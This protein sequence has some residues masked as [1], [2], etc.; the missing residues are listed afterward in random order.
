MKIA[1]IAPLLAG[2]LTL[3]AN[4]DPLPSLALVPS[5][6][7]VAG[8][9]GSTVG[10]GYDIDNPDPNNYVVLNDSFV[11]GDLASGTFGTYIDYVALQFIVIDPNTDTGPVPF[12]QGSA[13][14][15]EF[16]MDLFVPIPTEIPGGISVDYSIFSTDPNSPNFD[17]NSFITSGTLTATAE[18]DAAVPEPASVFLVGSLLL[19]LAF[20]ALR[21]RQRH[22]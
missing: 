1:I 4:A 6:G 2:L 20:L 11:T 21:R 9:P 22:A 19:P 7:T 3:G 17:P 12:A 15:G 8:L 10:F 13:G 14:L 18:V 16:D 5:G